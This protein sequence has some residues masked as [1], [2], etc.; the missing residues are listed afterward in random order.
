MAKISPL[1]DAD[2][3]KL[4]ATLSGSVNLNSAVLTAEMYAFEGFDPRVIAAVL[5]SYEADNTKFIKDM[6]DL[7]V[8]YVSR[9]TKTTDIVD[10]TKLASRREMSE[11]FTKYHVA[12]GA[13]GVSKDTVTLGRIASTFPLMAA[14]LMNDGRIGRVVGDLQDGLPRGYHFAA[15][16]GI[17]PNALFDKWVDWAVS[18][19]K[20]VNSS[21]GR[22]PDPAKVKSFANVTRLNSKITEVK[23]I[24]FQTSFLI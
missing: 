20:V 6:T 7:L 1:T 21:N 4:Q 10:K 16:A 11:L 12:I 18:F 17:V 14:R 9:G 15:A 23:R 19:D 5:K 13:R 2:Y 24:E 3:A 22:T 8:I